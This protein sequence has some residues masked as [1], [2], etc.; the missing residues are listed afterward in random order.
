MPDLLIHE[1]PILASGLTASKN[2]TVT[3]NR[4]TESDLSDDSIIYLSKHL[5]SSGPCGILCDISL[6]RTAGAKRP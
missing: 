1:R 4:K 5:H 2:K 6:A 3:L